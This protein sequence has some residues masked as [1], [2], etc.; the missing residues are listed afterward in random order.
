MTLRYLPL[1]FIALMPATAMAQIVADE[2][3]GARVDAPSTVTGT[4]GPDL[5]E[6]WRNIE[7]GRDTG[8]LSKPQAKAFR[9][10]AR[11]TNALAERY[12]R[13]GLTASEARELDMRARALDSLVGAARSR[14]GVK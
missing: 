12:S 7:K 5:H 11:Q 8:Q 6:T 1:A 14:N 9:K 2:P 4:Y 10:E 3:A 13:D